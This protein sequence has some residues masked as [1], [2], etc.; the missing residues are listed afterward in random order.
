MVWIVGLLQ[1]IDDFGMPAWKPVIKI[2]YLLLNPQ[3]GWRVISNAN[4]SV[5]FVRPFT[6]YYGTGICERSIEEK[7]LILTYNI[8]DFYDTYNNS[9]IY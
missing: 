6:D 2:D 3:K 1:A 9:S 7:I 5:A 8:Y 4:C